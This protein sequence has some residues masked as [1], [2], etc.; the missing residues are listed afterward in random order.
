[1]SSNMYHAKLNFLPGMC[2]MSR[3]EMSKIQPRK[4][5]S[6]I[7]SRICIFLEEGFSKVM[8]K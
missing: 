6:D 4:L 7:I 2:L 3:P 1:M 8:V 5:T